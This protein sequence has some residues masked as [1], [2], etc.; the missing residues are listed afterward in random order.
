M[1]RFWKSTT[2]A[3]ATTLLV[4]MPWLSASAQ[5][6]ASDTVFVSELT[7]EEVNLGNSGA[8]EFM[9][10]VY[11]VTE[12]GDYAEEY[13]WYTGGYSNFEV[14]L[15][16]GPTDATEYMDIT[17][18]NMGTF[19]DAWDVI[20]SQDDGDT[21]WFLG[22]ANYQGTDLLVY[23]EYQTDVFGD[24]D[25]AYMQFADPIDLLND[26]ELSQNEVSIGTEMLPM[27]PDWD[28]LESAIGGGSTDD[29]DATAET[30][31]NAEDAKL[32]DILGQVRGTSNDEE[33]EATA[34]TDLAGEDWESMGLEGADTWVSPTFDSEIT[35]DTDS[36]E[37]PTDYEYAI[38]LGDGWDSLTL[39]TVDGLGYV[40]ITVDQQFDNTPQSIVDYWQTDEF[41]ASR[42]PDVEVV[43]VATTRDSASIVYTSTNTAGEP[44]MTIMDVTFEDDGTAVF[45]EISAAPERLDDVYQQY[46][47]GVE[48]NGAPINLTWDVEEIQDMQP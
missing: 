31:V 34:E 26:M 48:L 10:D 25:L 41:L 8:F 14:I 29:V 46:I 17:D 13:I 33:V 37:F 47:D 35:W 1:N 43:D 6:A 24:V 7:G 23:F 9:P 28:A 18:S 3:V 4:A 38:Y 30:D 19:Y 22:E 5:P 16:Q 39:T 44:L 45:S 11:S 15:V 21:S 2:I 27:D 36:W 40:F 32:D 20:D 12:S 42:G